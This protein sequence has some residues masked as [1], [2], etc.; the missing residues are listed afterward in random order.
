MLDE[1]PLRGVRRVEGPAERVRDEKGVAE[2]PHAE[3]RASASAAESVLQPSSG[4][5]YC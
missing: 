5:R 2:V 3:G 1:L 4:M